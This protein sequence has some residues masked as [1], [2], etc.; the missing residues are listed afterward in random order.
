MPCPNST[1]PELLSPE[2]ANRVGSLWM[3]AAMAAFA[4]EDVL[5]KAAARSLPTAQVLVLFGLGGAALFAVWAGISGQ[6]LFAPAVLSPVMRLRIG[7][8]T[9]G[10][11]SSGWSRW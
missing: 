10:P 9:R 6:R 2:R 5:I 7:R 1:V 11:W 3:V 8:P 4:V